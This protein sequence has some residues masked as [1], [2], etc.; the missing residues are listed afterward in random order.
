MPSR[1]SSDPTLNVFT[2]FWYRL[3]ALKLCDLTDQQTVAKMVPQ[4]L[5]ILNKTI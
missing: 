1:N 4:L 2:L 3:T 5:V